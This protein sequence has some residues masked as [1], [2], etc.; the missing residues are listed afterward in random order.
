M[1]HEQRAKSI[2]QLVKYHENLSKS[3]SML[4]IQIIQQNIFFTVAATDKVQRTT[5]LPNLND[6]PTKLHSATSLLSE[7]T[8]ANT[9]QIETR[10]L[11]KASTEQKHLDESMNLEHNNLEI[12]NDARPIASN[13]EKILAFIDQK[14]H[15]SELLDEPTISSPIKLVSLPSLD[16]RRERKLSEENTLPMQ[17][18][19]SS[20]T[21]S[22]ISLPIPHSSMTQ[23]AS[24]EIQVIVLSFFTFTYL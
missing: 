10:T 4:I 17:T 5:S 2:A 6:K 11:S 9:I 21:S 16:T 15:I 20:A 23:P 1:T 24:S 12:L 3:N 22:T 13:E 7:R 18:D 8:A 19:G 14:I